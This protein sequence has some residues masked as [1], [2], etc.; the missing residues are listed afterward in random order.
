VWRADRF[1]FTCSASPSAVHPLAELSEHSACLLVGE[2]PPRCGSIASPSLQRSR[3]IAP[4][5]EGSRHPPASKEGLRRTS[6]SPSPLVLVPLPANLAQCIFVSSSRIAR[7][8]PSYSAGRLACR[9]HT[10]QP[11][12]A[13]PYEETGNVW[14]A[15]H[16]AFA[17][18]PTS[19]FSEYPI[20]SRFLE[21]AVKRCSS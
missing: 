6:I 11:R 19:E 4:F 5:G 13:S 1:S 14:F 18:H 17:F 9:S 12:H 15:S 10:I 7:A 21:R 8:W 2:W 16:F 3:R 20:S